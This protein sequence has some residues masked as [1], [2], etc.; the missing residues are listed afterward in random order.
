MLSC[1]TRFDDVNTR[2]K[3]FWNNLSMTIG[4]NMNEIKNRAI[5]ERLVSCNGDLL[6]RL[7]DEIKID[8]ELCLM[9]ANAPNMHVDIIPKE[10]RYDPDVSIALVRNKGYGL[11]YVPRELITYELCMEAIGKL[12]FAIMHVP[13]ELIDK[14]MCLYACEK[15]EGGND[16]LR[17]VPEHIKTQE[18]YRE[19]FDR[20][21]AFL[22][23][24][25][26]EDITYEMCLKSVQY[27][28]FTINSIDDKFKDYNLYLE[29]V[30]EVGSVL[31]SVPED[32]ITEDMFI[33]GL[34][35]KRTLIMQIPKKFRHR[36]DLVELYCMSKNCY[37][38]YLDDKELT[39][40]NI[41]NM[42]KTRTY[43][44]H[45]SKQVLEDYELSM[46]YCK[47][48]GFLP[49]YNNYFSKEFLDSLFNYDMAL[50][51]DLG[52][53]YLKLVLDLSSAILDAKPNTPH[54]IIPL[55]YS[56]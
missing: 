22:R 24:L 42:L 27:S 1:Y 39:K 14:E 8:K 46:E 25:P 12:A 50:A 20:Y 49:T 31:E 7:S 9:A 16:I 54:L 38:S 45:R 47:T 43:C 52:N 34:N 51:P 37:C 56:S 35:S 29:A 11:E 19:A 6:K 33:K 30:K 15:G 40:N 10:F 44:T 4:Y 55:L 36:A 17:F 21:G 13:K 26:K 2:L 5:I 48:F 41:L 23:Y 18:F 28:G 53:Q 3:Y 32:L